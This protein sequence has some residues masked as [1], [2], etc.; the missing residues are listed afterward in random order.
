M[1]NNLTKTTILGMSRKVFIT[2]VTVIVIVVAID[3]V[4]IYKS[5]KKLGG[6]PIRPLHSRIK[7]K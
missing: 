4:L 2:I 7:R 1:N 6:I 5:T 3:G